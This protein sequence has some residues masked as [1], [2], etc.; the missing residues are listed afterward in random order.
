MAR[1]DSWLPQDL[2]AMDRKDARTWCN[3]HESVCRGVVGF[4]A[5][6]YCRLMR[7][8]SMAVGLGL[9][10]DEWEL[11]KSQVKESFWSMRMIGAY[12]DLVP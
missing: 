2:R 1:I 7:D 4:S 3:R 11:M 6:Q 5:V 10:D 9:S 12:V 8:R